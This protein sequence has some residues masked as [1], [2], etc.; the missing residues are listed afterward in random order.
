M[1]AQCYMTDVRA[2][3]SVHLTYLRFLIVIHY[4]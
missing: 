2:V 4:V 1:K 3:L